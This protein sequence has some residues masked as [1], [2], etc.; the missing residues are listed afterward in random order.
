LDIRAGRNL[1]NILLLKTFFCGDWGNSFPPL[2]ILATCDA[3]RVDFGGLLHD[4]VKQESRSGNFALL[5]PDAKIATIPSIL[6]DR[7]ECGRPS[8]LI[9]VRNAHMLHYETTF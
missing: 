1:Q 9:L 6:P 7:H 5:N 8:L 3:F 4:E 2:G